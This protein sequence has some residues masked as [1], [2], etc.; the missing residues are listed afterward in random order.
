MKLV[1]IATKEVPESD[2]KWLYE[3]VKKLL[4]YK[5]AM[6]IALKQTSFLYRPELGHRAALDMLAKYD[7]LKI[8]PAKNNTRGLSKKSQKE[9]IKILKNASIEY[10]ISE[11]KWLDLMEFIYKIDLN[12]HEVFSIK[13]QE[14]LLKEMVME[15][16]KFLDKQRIVI[17]EKDFPENDFIQRINIPLALKAIKNSEGVIKINDVNLWLLSEEHEIKIDLSLNR[18]PNV[19]SLIYNT[20]DHTLCNGNFKYPISGLRR[21]VFEYLLDQKNNYYPSIEL[22]EEFGTDGRSI[23]KTV[24]DIRSMIKKKLMLDGNDIIEGIKSDGYRINYK[25]CKIKKVRK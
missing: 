4:D 25:K 16:F 23:N 10:E 15:K 20:H 9:L 3:T 12:I 7:F 24:G 5:I 13:K 6:G 17:T 1:T 21:S 14:S 22:A 18:S 8:A 11:I 19:I 2:K